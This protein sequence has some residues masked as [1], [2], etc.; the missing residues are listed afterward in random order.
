MNQSMIV[1]V[2]NTPLGLLALLEGGGNLVGGR[3]YIFR[4]SLGRI[5]WDPGFPPT[6]P[7]PD[8]HEM[9]SFKLSQVPDLSSQAVEQLDQQ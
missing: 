5:F 9:R 3:K 2:L 1:W 4:S 6:L 7:F 8:H